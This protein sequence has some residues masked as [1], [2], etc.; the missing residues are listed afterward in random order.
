MEK[1]SSTAIKNKLTALYRQYAD[2]IASGMPAAMNRQRESAIS[3][4]DECGLPEKGCE[5]YRFTDTQEIKKI[6]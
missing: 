1:V 4:F 3:Q 6:I 5:R 2:S